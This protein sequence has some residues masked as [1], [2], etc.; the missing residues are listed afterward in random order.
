MIKV[1]VQ[2]LKNHLIMETKLYY[3]STSR[4]FSLVCAI[5]LLTACASV[6]V[7]KNIDWFVK[8]SNTPTTINYKYCVSAAIETSDGFDPP[9]GSYMNSMC[10]DNFSNAKNKVLNNCTEKNK[11]KCM[12]VYYFER[13][14]DKEVRTFQPENVARKTEENRL[15]NI[16]LDLQERIRVG[17]ICED[18]GHRKQT[19]FFKQCVEQRMAEPRTIHPLSKWAKLPMI[20]VINA[21]KEHHNFN[22][23]Y[24]LMTCIRVSYDNYGTSP[25]STDVQNFYTLL[26]AVEEDFQR[27][28]I[29]MI[30][31]NAELIK[32]WQMTI[33]TSNNASKAR[34]S[35]SDPAESFNRHQRYQD[36][37]NRGGSICLP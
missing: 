15:K 25:N 12:L 33:E 35:N 10:S 3:R 22:E 37:L 23:F 13:N 27:R 34:S 19:A 14:K 7:E 16:E 5:L 36:C 4:V 17:Q 1:V 31:A 28:K 6:V 21:C 11:V 20:D 18:F 30:K 32:A 29:T 8:S 9:D 24:G 26:M 2:D